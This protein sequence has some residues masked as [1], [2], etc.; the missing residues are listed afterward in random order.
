TA[1]IEIEATAARLRGISSGSGNMGSRWFRNQFRGGPG[2][3][4]EVVPEPVREVVP[5]PV[6]EVVP[7]PVAAVVPGPVAEMCNG[8]T[9][10]AERTHPTP[11]P[12]H[13][14]YQRRSPL[15][16]DATPPSARPT[17]QRTQRRSSVTTLRATR[18]AHE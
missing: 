18:R 4:C 17:P 7:E 10:S 2:A 6:P 15:D 11:R 16:F 13:D 3:S 12:K 9:I 1:L 5:G 8:L 14:P